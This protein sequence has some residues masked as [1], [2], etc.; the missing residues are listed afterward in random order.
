MR[1]GCPL[2][3][4]QLSSVLVA[5]VGIPTFVQ[6]LT[7]V[8]HLSNIRAALNLGNLYVNLELSMLLLDDGIEKNAIYC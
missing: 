7:Y 2:S 6:P 4:S 1:G 8:Q 3:C 5:N